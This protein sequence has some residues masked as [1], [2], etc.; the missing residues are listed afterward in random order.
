MLGVHSIVQ[1]VHSNIHTNCSFQRETKFSI[2]LSRILKFLEANNFQLVC[3]KL[4][5]AKIPTLF[6][7]T[8]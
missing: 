5:H 3:V 8:L 2:Q 4:Q 1:S 7:A 6:S